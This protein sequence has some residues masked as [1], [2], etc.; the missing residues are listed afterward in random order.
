MFD[1]SDLE[2]LAAYK[3][4]HP[5]VSLYLHLDPRLRG[6][7][8]AYR[9]RLKSLL[10]KIAGRA[11]KEDLSAIEDFFEK[12]FDWLGRSVVVFSSQASELWRTESFAVPLRSHA[13]VGHKPFI[14]PLADL[15]D[16]YGS[17]SVALVDQQHL[18][19]FHFHLGELK[20]SEKLEGDEIRR[21]KGG[22]GGPQSGAIRGQDPTG[23]KREIVRGNLKDFAEAL[24]SFC[25]RH[26]SQRLLLGGSEATVAQFEEMLSPAWQDRVAGAVTLSLQA[27]E[28]EVM[29]RSLE[30]LQA[31][32]K[33][34][35]NELVETILTMAGKGANGVTGLENTLEAVQTGRAQALVLAEGLQKPGFRCIG[36]DHLVVEQVETCLLCGADMTPTSNVIEHALRWIIEHGGRVEFLDEETSSMLTDEIG[37]LLR[38]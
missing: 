28:K 30:V 18:H 22:G 29:T 8:E 1:H 2:K 20:A 13:H 36:C 5:V 26:K 24:E 9:A 32:Q 21:L 25:K 12:D 38:Y 3:G 19:L 16:T 35:Q 7:R 33:A 23:H 15:I 37:A 6:A 34:R 4:K 11:S 10:K 27:S 14:T 31:N 17:Y